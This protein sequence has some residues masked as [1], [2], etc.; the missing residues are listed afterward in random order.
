MSGIKSS[1]FYQTVDLNWQQRIIFNQLIYIGVIMSK[2]IKLVI[3]MALFCLANAASALEVAP[4]FKI[5]TAKGM[6]DLS[7]LKGQVIY[8]DFWASWCIPCRKSF[9]WMNEMQNKYKDDG[10]KIVAVN[11]DKTRDV[12]DKFLKRPPADFTIAYD[13]GGQ[14]A[15]SYKL[16]G[17]P[18]SY[19]IDRLGHIQAT[20]VGF[21]KKD[22]DKLE[23]KIKDLLNQ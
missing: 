21:R 1:Q 6:I 2:C 13:P 8:L 14:L 5:P 7:E 16:A 23:G 9:P 20:H 4:T 22:Q 10:L 17:M 19:L 11:L 15:Q 3:F 12:I 18:T